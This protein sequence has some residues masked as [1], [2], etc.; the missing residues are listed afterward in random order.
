MPCVGLL[1]LQLDLRRRIQGGRFLSRSDSEMHMGTRLTSGYDGS[2]QGAEY[3]SML[4]K[5]EVGC[6]G[7][8]ESC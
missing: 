6:T 7:G 5:C 2:G 1:G 3:G 4:H 8:R